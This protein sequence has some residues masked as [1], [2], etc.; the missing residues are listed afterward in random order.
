MNILDKANLKIKNKYPFTNDITN[1]CCTFESDN[2][3]Q[4]NF[5]SIGCKNSYNGKCIICDYGR[6]RNITKEEMLHALNFAISN[7]KGNPRTLL[8]NTYGSI[9]DEFEFSKENLIAL[10]IEINKLNF[11][12][13]ILETHYKTITQEKL[14]LIKKYINNKNIFFEIG[15]E[16]FNEKYRKYCLNKDINNNE[17]FNTINLIKENNCFV[18]ANILIGIPFLDTYQQ[19]NDVIESINIAFKN[20]ID[21]VTLFPI[22]IKKYTFLYELYKN[23]LYKPISSWMIIEI[24]NNV[25][26]EY[27]DK[28]TFAWF[29]NRD[30]IYS[31]NTTIF[32]INCDKC[33]KP[34]NKFLE[35]F[36]S[37]KNDNKIKL[38]DEINIISKQCDCRKNFI[39]ELKIKNDKSFENI[40]KDYYDFI[41]K[42]IVGKG[43]T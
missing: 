4:I 16:R 24:L 17:L 28:I 19:L 33:R 42:H 40:I 6:G 25:E 38:L 12:S 20:K 41:D 2:L 21:E 23:N 9:L 31:N 29:G 14:D 43:N 37:A 22:N 8:I 35:D 1:Y 18:S 3:F 36:N 5:E 34:L 32:P 27:L 39:N 13:I 11:K 15:I 30:M 10:L 26:K 7:I